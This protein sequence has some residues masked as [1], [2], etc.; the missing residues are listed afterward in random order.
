M[1]S[2]SSLIS[3]FLVLRQNVTKK[4][5]FSVCFCRQGINNLHNGRGH[6]GEISPRQQPIT[7]RDFTGSNLCDIINIDQKKG[8][9]HIILPQARAYS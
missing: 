2:S 5:R 7:A 4:R 1:G 8:A 9:D 6:Y 3:V